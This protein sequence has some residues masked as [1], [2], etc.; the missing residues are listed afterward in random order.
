MLKRNHFAYPHINQ[1]KYL[2]SF[3]SDLLCQGNLII[4]VQTLFLHAAHGGRH[5][6]NNFRINPTYFLPEKNCGRFS[7]NL[8]ASIITGF[9]Q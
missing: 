4:I 5:L 9:S 1:R 7:S 8:N 2:F 3:H 6:E